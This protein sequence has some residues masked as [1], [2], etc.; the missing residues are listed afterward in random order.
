M[1][2]RD[3]NDWFSRRLEELANQPLEPVEVSVLD[4]GID[5]THP[6]MAGRIVDSVSVQIIDGRPQIE[7]REPGK[8]NDVY[9]HGTAVASVIC[10]LAPNAR[11]VD[12]GVLG[13]DSYGVPAALTAGLEYAVGR[14]SRIINMSL[15]A[16][17]EFAPA[18]WRL[19]ERAY[20]QNQL[21][22]ASKRNTPFTDDGFPAEFSSSI[23]VDRGSFPS[24]YQLRFHPD[25]ATEYSAHGDEVIVAAAGGG[26]TVKT[27]SSFSTPAVAALCALLIGAHPSLRSFEVKTILKGF[28]E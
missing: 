20:R 14:K 16:R 3:L 28:A 9:G 18:L 15:A 24:P 22:V 2:S 26:Y 13:G 8:N 17:A 19:C 23:G 11:I 27:G 6:D 1:A 7:P 21:V 10:R 12:V 5:S 4:S 25:R